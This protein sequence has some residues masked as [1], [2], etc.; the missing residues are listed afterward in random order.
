MACYLIL[1][2]KQAFMKHLYFLI[3]VVLLGLYSCENPPEITEEFQDVETFYF[4]N[5][6]RF[7]AIDLENSNINLDDYKTYEELVTAMDKNSCDD[8]TNV[9]S[10]K[11]NNT[12]FKIAVFKDCSKSRGGA[13]YRRV[14]FFDFQNDSLLKNYNTKI[15]PKFFNE[16]VQVSLDEQLRS[17]YF[18]K[19]KLR[20]I[21]ISVHYAH[22][23]RNTPVE[24]L[25][26][27]LLFITKTMTE[28]QEKYDLQISYYLE[29]DTTHILPPP[30][31]PFP[32]N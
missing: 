25:K 28:I 18:N 29:I 17:P 13:C 15:S 23:R 32:N 10:F 20:R 11:H 14:D 16:E 4:P 26:N 27:T 30:P 24:N 12:H 6:E 1:K 31:P 22:E 2:L 7:N 5:K 9:L 3:M 8:K 19:E 21:L